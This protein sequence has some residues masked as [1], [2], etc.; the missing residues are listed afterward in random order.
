MLMTSESRALAWSLRGVLAALLLWLMVGQAAAQE[1]SPEAS[2][3]AAGGLEG[4]VAYLIAQQQSDGGFLG[5]SG[6]SDAGTTA[7]AIVAFAAAQQ[8]GIEVSEPLERAWKFVFD[9]ALVFAQTGPGQAAKLVLAAAA[10]GQNPEDINGVLPLTLA[11]AG[12]NPDTGLFGTGVYD[13]ALAVMALVVAGQT[14]PPEALDALETTQIADGSWAFD[15]STAEGSGD[16][17][18]TAM[19]IQALVA[20]GAAESPL[21]QPALDYLAT[22]W[23]DA[24][25]FAFSLAEPLVPDAN[26]T[27]LVVQALI[28][29]GVDVAESGDLDALLAFQNS[30]GAFRYLDSDPSDNLYA[31]LQAVPALAGL[32]LPVGGEAGSDGTPAASAVWQLAA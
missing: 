6:S 20:A 7:D 13:H 22:V 32:A 2:P 27:A 10:A 11:T 1:A 30:S 24:G 18:T 14:V 26:S 8:A 4:A 5:F 17:N 15:G 31:T 23:A 25:G 3:A 19:V 9:N 16:S 12:V 29:T 28:A 21:I